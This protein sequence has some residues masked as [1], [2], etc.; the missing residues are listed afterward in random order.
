MK[1]F[2]LGALFIAHLCVAQE[3]ASYC[4]Y[5]NEQARAQS[6]IL[7]T[8]SVVGGVTQSETGLPMQVVA[9]LQNSIS[10]DFKA[11]RTT[12]V[13][14][15]NCALYEQ[16]TAAQAKL[17]YAVPGIEKDA[18]LNRERLLVAADQGI[19][20]M[21]DEA[22]MKIKA[23]NLTRQSQYALI[24][25]RRRLQSELAATRGRAAAIFVPI[26]VQQGG[27]S[28]LVA[29]KT[30][31]EAAEARAQAR[32]DRLTDWDVTVTAG[33]HHEITATNQ[34][35]IVTVQNSPI[36]VY[37]QVSVTYNLADRAATRHR[38]RSIA[39]FQSWKAAQ[40]DDVVRQAVIL[41]TQMED[42]VKVLTAALNEQL[43]QTRLID[44]DLKSI[45]GIDSPEA[46]EFRNRLLL[47]RLLLHVELADSEFRI[48]SLQQYLNSNW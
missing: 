14:R 22:E 19:I 15:L 43:E 12:D 16:I 23:H 10:N 47:D 24:V 6:D 31:T 44:D 26:Q 18:L 5:I 35:N 17:K 38:N 1:M 36:G 46:Y 33:L 30:A 37:G 20:R 34:T 2:F 32:L 11:R 29:G 40:N 39:A 45:E 48:H 8:P 9:G 4:S 3:T 41:R 25:E 21:I 7:R 42:Q 28:D 13:A 27:L